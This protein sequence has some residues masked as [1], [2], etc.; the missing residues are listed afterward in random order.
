[1]EWLSLSKTRGERPENFLDRRA[2]VYAAYQETL[3]RCATVDF[4]DLLLMGRSLLR[5]CEW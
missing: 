3:R 1:M 2:V 4:D 5:D